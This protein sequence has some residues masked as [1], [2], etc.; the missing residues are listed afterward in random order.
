MSLSARL[1]FH[2][3]TRR[4]SIIARQPARR[5]TFQLNEISRCHC[6]VLKRIAGRGA[7]PL[8]HVPFSTQE[9]V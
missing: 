1:G 8:R 6:S 3:H 4:G 7:S 2:H 9:R 5:R